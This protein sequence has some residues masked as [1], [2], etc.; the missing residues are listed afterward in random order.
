MPLFRRSDGTLV[1]GLPAIRRGM[2]YFLRGR[3]ES[4][5]YVEVRCDVTGRAKRWL[6]AYNRAYAGEQCTFLHLFLYSASLV[7]HE[8]P[9]LDRFVSGRRIYQRTA[10]TVSLMVKESMQMEAP[11]Y[12]VK[13]PLAEP[14][15]S[16]ADYS[17][18][19]ADILCN[20]VRQF[21][22]PRRER[23]ELCSMLPDLLV[24]AVLAIRSWLDD[25]NLLPAILLRDDPLY[26]SRCS[27]R[28]MG[29]LGLPDAFHHLYEH[30]NC[31]GFAMICTLQ[32]AATVVDG[33][34]NVVVR[35][36]LPIRWTVDDRVADGFVC[37]ARW[38][39]SQ[40]YIGRPRP[41]PRAPRG[42]SEGNCAIDSHDGG[43]ALRMIH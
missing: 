32:K 21:H 19:A 10:S 14:N 29:P 42:R 22:E 30:G 43:R 20:G 23:N 41:I 18:R 39:R 31:S 36:I 13:L 15:E 25:W 17:R 9:Q 1:K 3:N 38:K 8:F 12:S 35:D 2:P 5:V 16:L 34:G 11:L 28:T 27:C 37:A 24:R 26:T 40:G 7:L 6:W 33:D 4:V